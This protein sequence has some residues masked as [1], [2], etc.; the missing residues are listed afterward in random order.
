MAGFKTKFRTGDRVRLL[1]NVA[2]PGSAGHE[3]YIYV[4]SHI[5]GAYVYLCSNDPHFDGACDSHVILTTGYRYNYVLS[6][7]SEDTE[8]YYM[9]ML[10]IIRGGDDEKVVRLFKNKLLT[11]S[12]D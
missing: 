8:S 12:T 3:A 2:R 1:S 4:K 11:I 10:E 7:G 5:D 9:E 6:L